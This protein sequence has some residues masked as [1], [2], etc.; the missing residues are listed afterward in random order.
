[1]ILTSDY[2]ISRERFGIMS[3]INLFDWSGKNMI[4]IDDDYVNYIYLKDLL[5]RTNVTLKRATSLHQSYR[6]MKSFGKVDLILINMNIQG[7]GN[8]EGLKMLK[9]MYP[10]IPVIGITKS[11]SFYEESTKYLE[12]GCDTFLNKHFDSDQLLSTINDLIY[13]Y[14]LPVSLNHKI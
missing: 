1:M 14:Q 3:N 12:A 11:N 6:H 4:I 7:D 5:F 10:G 9:R 2:K 13:K 8:C